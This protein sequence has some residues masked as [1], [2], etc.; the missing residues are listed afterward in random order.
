MRKLFL[1][2][3]SVILCGLGLQAQTRT[4]RGTVLDASN[5]E[6]LIGATIMPIG[7]GNGA[8]ADIDGHFTITVPANVK[9][10]NVSYVGFTTKTV[11]LT[12]DMTIY[13]D[14]SSKRLKTVR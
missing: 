2:M 8:A 9:K 13:L 1:L 7:G 5:Q 6:P 11:D 12:P 10:A 14:Q 3:I 4:I